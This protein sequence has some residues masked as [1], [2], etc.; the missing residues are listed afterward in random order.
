V[1]NI[2]AR[3]FTDFD[4]AALIAAGIPTSAFAVLEYLSRKRQPAEARIRAAIE[5]SYYKHPLLVAV[6]VV[7]ALQI[8]QAVISFLVGYGVATALAPYNLSEDDKME[9]GLTTATVVIVPLVALLLVFIARAAAHRIE[10]HEYAWLALALVMNIVLNLVTALALIGPEEFTFSA[11]DV[12]AIAVLL[13]LYFGAAWLGVRWGERTQAIH[14]LSQA[15]RDL[16]PE[17]RAA[18][19]ELAMPKLETE[20]VKKA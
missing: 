5:G 1:I 16:S 9:V 7:F 17:N 14:V 13:A 6:Y 18:L 20:A 2:V 8:A 3:A 12:V 19:V 10:R 4:T 11:G 15:Y